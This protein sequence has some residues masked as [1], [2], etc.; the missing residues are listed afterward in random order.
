MDKSAL[1]RRY[2]AVLNDELGWEALEGDDG[3]VKFS[4]P[5]GGCLAC[6]ACSSPRPAASTRKSC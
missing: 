6:L 5:I 1:T 3:E 4:S 2:L